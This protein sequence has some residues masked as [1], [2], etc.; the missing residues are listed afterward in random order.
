MEHWSKPENIFATFP[1][2][3]CID[4]MCLYLP[5][6]KDTT[7]TGCLKAKKESACLS[8]NCSQVS[9]HSPLLWSLRGAVISLRQSVSVWGNNSGF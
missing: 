2:C 4:C 6:D 7:H 3:A 9:H 5:A 1:L 8:L